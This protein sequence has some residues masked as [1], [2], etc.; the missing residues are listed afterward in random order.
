MDPLQPNGLR[1]S[2]GLG[3]ATDKMDL[4]RRM[5]PPQPDSFKRRL[6]GG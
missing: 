2:C 5:W 1:L 3:A 4:L 6:G